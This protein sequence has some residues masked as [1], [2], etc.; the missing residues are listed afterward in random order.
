MRVVPERS[1][2]WHFASVLGGFAAGPFAAARLGSLL[3]PG[4]ELVQ[5][6]AAFGFAAVFLGAFVGVGVGLLA[7]AVTE[8]TIPAAAGAWTLLG[9]GYGLALWAAAHHGYLPFPEPE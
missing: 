2:W 8:L 4:S 3:V 1:P 7:G 9:T 5:T 6:V